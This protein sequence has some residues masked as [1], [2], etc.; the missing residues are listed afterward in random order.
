MLVPQEP[1][2]P[3]VTVTFT[4]AGVERGTTFC[5]PN[6]QLSG[7]QPNTTYTARITVTDGFRPIVVDSSVTTDSNGDAL[8]IPFSLSVPNTVEAE[9]DG[10]SSGTS[11]LACSA[12]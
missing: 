9:V 6:L 7:F 4:F 12:P 5:Y 2:N 1:L 11:T 3:V 8:L 10:V